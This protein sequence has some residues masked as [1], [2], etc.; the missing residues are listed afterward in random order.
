MAGTPVQRP[1]PAVRVEPTA[2]L[3][4]TIGTARFCGTA[5]PKATS[6]RLLPR[7]H[8]RSPAQA[9]EVIVPNGFITATSADHVPGV[10]DVRTVQASPDTQ[11]VVD[12]Q[13]TG[14]PT[15][16]I[17]PFQTGV[18]AKGFVDQ[19]KLPKKSSATQRSTDGQ[20]MSVRPP[21]GAVPWLQTGSAAVTSVV[22]SGAPPVASTAAQCVAVGH[23]SAHRLLAP[24]TC[25]KPRHTGP[26]SSIVPIL[27][28]SSSTAAP[29][30]SLIATQ[31][32]TVGHERSLG[33]NGGGASTQSGAAAAGWC[34]TAV[35]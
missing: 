21:S 28:T 31:R 24:S 33:V 1:R 4:L 15:W 25:F 5:T 30:L 7:R 16:V 14:V 9:T 20:L 27:L 3:P 10:V 2:A 23:D 12:E 32:S 8:R 13:T 11:N 22:V 19:M 6:P 26:G 18:A 29:S 35:Q 34:E 17:G